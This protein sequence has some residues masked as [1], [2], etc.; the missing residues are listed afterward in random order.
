MLARFDIVLV[1]FPFTNGPNVKPR[2][3]MVI[4][5]SERHQE[6]LLAFIR[7]RVAG[8]ALIDELDIPADHPQFNQSGRKVS[9]RCRLTRRTLLAMPLIRRRIGSLPPDHRHTCVQIPREIVSAALSL[10]ACGLLAS[11]RRVSRSP[12]LSAACPQRQAG[13]H[14]MPPADLAPS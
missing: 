2:P 14:T 7:S 9:S 1:P 8:A 3:A 4:R 10:R 12:G 13:D 5:L 11:P 6:G